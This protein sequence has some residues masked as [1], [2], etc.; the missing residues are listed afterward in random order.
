MRQTE[1]ELRSQKRSRDLY[2]PNLQFMIAGRDVVK[3]LSRVEH[4]SA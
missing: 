3:A 2:V 4:D 1:E